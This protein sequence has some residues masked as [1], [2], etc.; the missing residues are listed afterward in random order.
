LNELL[1]LCPEKSFLINEVEKQWEEVSS[2]S[3]DAFFSPFLLSL[4][5]RSYSGLSSHVSVLE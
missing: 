5:R 1:R 4:S 3:P 2:V